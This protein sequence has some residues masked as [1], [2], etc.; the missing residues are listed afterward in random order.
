VTDPS[1]ELIAFLLAQ[2]D[3]AEA[4]AKLM[5]EHYPPPWDLADRGWMA[6]VIADEP[7][8][9]EVTRLEQWAD[10]PQGL[11]SPDLGDIIEHIAL[12]GPD[13]VLADI[14]SKRRIL[15]EIVDDANGLDDSLDLDRRVGERDLATEPRLGDLLAKI[16]AEPYASHDGYKEAWRPV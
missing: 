12:N 15:T 11:D 10:M 3:R 1:D 13:F 5:A 6:R 2:Y 16:L 14:A 9:R 7:V 8:F 4:A